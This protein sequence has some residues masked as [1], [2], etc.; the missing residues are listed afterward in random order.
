VNSFRVLKLYFEA[1]PFLHE[2]MLCLI[3]TYFYLLSH[4]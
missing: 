3:S 2:K 4:T 1:L